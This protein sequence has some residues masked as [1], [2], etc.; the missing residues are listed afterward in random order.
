[1]WRVGLNLDIPLRSALDR[2]NLIYAGQKTGS[3]CQ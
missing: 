3:E 1:M 2:T